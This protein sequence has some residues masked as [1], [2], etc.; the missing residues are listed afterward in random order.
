MD[1]YIGALPFT[2][3]RDLHLC[4][5]HGI[6]YQADMTVTAEYDAEYLAKCAG[7]PPEQVEAINAARRDFVAKHIGQVATLVDVGVGDG[8]FIRARPQTWGI[9]IN[10]E[11]RKWLA[12]VDRLAA[13]VFDFCAAS[14][15][16]TLEHVPDPATDYLD[17]LRLGCHLFVS[18]PI[19]EDLTRIRESRHYRP[20][21][22]LYY[23]T[24]DGLVT[25]LEWHGFRLLEASDFETRHGRANIGSFAFRR[26]AWPMASPSS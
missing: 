16:D 8:A 15:W 4:T 17:D 20:G 22:H 14:M 13:N 10:P 23:F 11:A 3:D 6:A 2:V 25:W 18:V 26:S 21:E 9:D 7:H 24:A 12:F 19:F 1:R 5:E